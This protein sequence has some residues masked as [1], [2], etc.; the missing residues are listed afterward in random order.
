MSFQMMT[1]KVSRYLCL[2]RIILPLMHILLFDYVSKRIQDFLVVNSERIYL[3]A[4]ELL[5]TAETSSFNSW[6]C[7]FFFM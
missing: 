7:G 2:L 6:K 4:K 3:G 1:Y 5:C